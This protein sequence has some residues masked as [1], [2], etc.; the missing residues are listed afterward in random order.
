M[1]TLNLKKTISYL[2]N[3]EK[4]DYFFKEEIKNEVINILNQYFYNKIINNTN[5]YIEILD[6]NNK[7]ILINK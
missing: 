7:N 1:E 4:E 3:F 5:D 6:I 2:S